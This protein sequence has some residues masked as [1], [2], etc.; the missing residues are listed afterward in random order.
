[1]KYNLYISIDVYLHMS[2]YTQIQMYDTKGVEADSHV[3]KLFNE[4][5]ECGRKARPFT[6]QF[7]NLIAFP[8]RQCFE[9]KRI[10]WI[11]ELLGELKMK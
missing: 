5:I 9:F 8:I 4:W 3:T 10:R 2:V 11:N 7:I 6:S 1:M